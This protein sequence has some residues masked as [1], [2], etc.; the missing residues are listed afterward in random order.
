LINGSSRQIFISIQNEVNTAFSALR[1][2]ERKQEMGVQK[3]ETHSR[4]LSISMAEAR[5]VCSVLANVDRRIDRAKKGNSIFAQMYQKILASGNPDSMELMVDLLIKLKQTPHVLHRVFVLLEKDLAQALECRIRLTRCWDDV[6]TVQRLVHIHR[7]MIMTDHLTAIAMNLE[8]DEAI[9]Q[10]K[11]ILNALDLTFPSKSHVATYDLP[12]SSLKDLLHQGIAN[13]VQTYKTIE[14]IDR[15]KK[16]IESTIDQL[17]A[18][19]VTS[20]TEPDEESRVESSEADASSDFTHSPP[21]EKD[22]N[23]TGMHWKTRR[24]KNT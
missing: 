3:I 19:R 22:K 10:V 20:A 15:Q 4:F 5:N 13:L 7:I 18:I 14:H 2:V 23:G 9:Q 6:L 16:E 11:S 17:S 1:E 21:R 24:R 12:I 8:D